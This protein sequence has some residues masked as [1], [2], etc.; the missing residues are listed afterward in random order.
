ML[1]VEDDSAI[2]HLLTQYLSREG[3]E[4]DVAADGEQGVELARDIRPDVIILDLMLPGIDG[5]EVCRRV[6]VFSNAYILILTA[7][8][9][10]VDRVIGLSVGADD[11]V[12]K[13]FSPRELSARVQALLRRPR[14][15]H[16]VEEPVRRFGGLVIDAA[17][18]E[19]TLAGAPVELTRT[20]FDLLEALSA[21]PRAVFERRRLLEHVWGSDWYGDD[22]VI[23]V[24][25]A[26]LR[27]KLGDDPSASR[28]VRTVRGIGYRMGDGT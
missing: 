26:N 15:D 14:H 25:V 21:R 24:H 12:V 22:H 28:Y 7:R 27:R 11:Y 2:A 13:P 6:R 23:D 17:A 10:E 5:I 4:V 16:A 3:F 9:D 20:E 1:V 8:G 18:R 19:V